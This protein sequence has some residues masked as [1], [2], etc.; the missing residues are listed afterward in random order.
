VVLAVQ[1]CRGWKALMDQLTLVLGRPVSPIEARNL[2]RTHRETFHQFWR[3]S[4]AMVDDA[5]LTSMASTLW[6]WTLAV[7]GEVNP[8]TLRNFPMQA[9]GAEM[10]RLAC[11][12][13]IEHGLELAAPVHDGILLLAPINRIRDDVAMMRA[14]MAEASRIVL[15]GFELSTEIAE[16]RIVVYPDRYMDAAGKEMWDRVMRLLEAIEHENA[17]LDL[18]DLRGFV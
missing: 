13:G 6:G 11:C 14:I 3:W 5:M 12:L 4:D 1:Y 18:E 7:T 2:L 9:T 10:L 15:A 8:R 17:G 16:D